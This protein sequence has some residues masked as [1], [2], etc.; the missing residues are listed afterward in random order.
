MKYVLADFRIIFGILLAHLLLFFSF[1]E[2]AVFWYI[3]TGSILILIIYARLQETMNDKASFYKYFLYGILSGVLLYILF[4]LGHQS[5]TLVHLPFD[6]TIRNL[7]RWYA[8]TLFWHYIAL[9]LVAVPGEEIFW[10][11]FIQKRL[12]KYFN[13][14]LSIIAAS[15]LYGTV[16][17]YSGS[18]LLV[19][20][21]FISGTVWGILYWW[22]RSM[23]LVIV[24]HITFDLL[25]FIIF[26]F[27]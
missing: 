25:I 8:P 20:S 4:W 19:L 10:R 23:P 3:F 13:P 7:Y 21:A 24:S 26:P 27:T 22:K 2:R 15:V 9:F 5:F 18:F 16:N 12:I 6:K 17:I 1:H 11:G 14:V